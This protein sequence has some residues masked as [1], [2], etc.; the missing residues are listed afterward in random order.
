MQ[1]AVEVNLIGIVMIVAG[2]VHNATHAV[3][4]QLAKQHEER[5]PFINP[6]LADLY[7]YYVQGKRKLAYIARKS[8]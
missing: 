3:V 7:D 4:L 2:S 8:H 6:Y 5:P 1:N